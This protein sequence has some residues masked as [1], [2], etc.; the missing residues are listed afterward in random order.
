MAS[1]NF[2]RAKRVLRSMKTSIGN[3][4]DAVIGGKN[5]GKKV[6]Y[7]L[8]CNIENEGPSL[9]NKR[10]HKADVEYYNRIRSAIMESGGLISEVARALGVRQITIEQYIKRHPE[11]RVV[12]QEARSAFIDK[13][14]M[15]LR[16]LVDKNNLTAILFTLKCLGQE[17]GYIETPQ[18]N[19][20]SDAPIIIKLVPAADVKMPKLPKP[21]VIDIS[22]NNEDDD[23]VEEPISIEK[24]DG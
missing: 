16:R 8:T 24:A 2:K 21:K 1:E 23:D 11:L 10:G 6:R 14:E 3:A 12:I 4:D 22:P 9:D 7:R 17:R 15:A 20:D 13:A 18:R 5:N 19:R